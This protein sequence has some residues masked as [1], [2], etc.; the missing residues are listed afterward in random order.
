VLPD[1]L[2]SFAALAAISFDLVGSV[3]RSLSAPLVSGGPVSGDLGELRGGGGRF[4]VH[5]HRIR[6]DMREVDIDRVWIQRK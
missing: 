3:Q 1:V 2:E 5:V 6:V 4:L